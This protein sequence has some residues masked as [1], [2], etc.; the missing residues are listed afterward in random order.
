[1]YV[2][3]P[4]K[5]MKMDQKATIASYL[6]TVVDLDMYTPIQCVDKIKLPM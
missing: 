1:M 2:C 5:L 6:A 3:V 4:T